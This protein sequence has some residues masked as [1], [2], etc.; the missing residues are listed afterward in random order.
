MK[1]TRRVKRGGASYE[2]FSIELTPAHRLLNR[3]V[4]ELQEDFYEPSFNSKRREGQRAHCSDNQTP[5]AWTTPFDSDPGFEN[6][7]KAYEEC[8]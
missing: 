6:V 2:R 7:Q 3:L 8:A 5:S 1:G 4:H